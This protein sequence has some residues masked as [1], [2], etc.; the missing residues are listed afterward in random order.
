MTDDQLSYDAI[1]AIRELNRFLDSHSINQQALLHALQGQGNGHGW[2][3]GYGAFG[4]ACIHLLNQGGS[5]TTVIVRWDPNSR[6]VN[7]E[8]TSVLPSLQLM[9]SGLADG[10]MFDGPLNTFTAEGFALIMYLE[11]EASWD[12]RLNVY[13]PQGRLHRPVRRVLAGA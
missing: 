8:L 2:Q 1:M 13:D 6:G 12:L 4:S 9:I 5:R 3:R 7:Q 10:H 11:I